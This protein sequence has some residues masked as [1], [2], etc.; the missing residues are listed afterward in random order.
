MLVEKI[1]ER[2]RRRDALCALVRAGQRRAGDERVEDQKCG[3]HNGQNAANALRDLL[4][5]ARHGGVNA[6][7]PDQAKQTPDDAEH[8]IRAPV[9]IERR[10]AVIPRYRS[11][12]HLLPPAAQIFKRRA[13]DAARDENDRAVLL[14]ELIETKR[15]DR[16]AAAVDRLKRPVNQADAQLDLMGDEE[17]PALLEHKTGN[18]SD[19]KDPEQ[20]RQVH[21]ESKRAILRV[22]KGRF[23]FVEIARLAL[24]LPALSLL[25]RD[26]VSGKLLLVFLTGHVRR[27][28]QEAALKKVRFVQKRSVAFLRI[29]LRFAQL[30]V[31]IQ[32]VDA[33]RRA[34]RA[35]GDRAA[36][37]VARF[38]H[39]FCKLGKAPELMMQLLHG[40]RCDHDV[41]KQNGEKRGEDDPS[42]CAIYIIQQRGKYRNHK[43][44]DERE[45]HAAQ[46][47]ERH[48]DIALIVPL[49]RRVV[50]QADL[51]SLM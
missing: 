4:N 44:L 19:E 36:D 18:A 50:A 49:E 3:E 26:A 16:C 48:A 38:A 27:G 7:E 6:L 13:D 40:D 15:D 25:R 2:G 5:P 10:A 30:V 23:V 9:D 33:L 14:V 1:L 47:R 43:Q 22:F 24:R 31:E 29:F 20:L 35:L 8:Q 21:A 46:Q 39:A 17:C 51:F 37:R 11:E 12:D 41:E 45:A 32:L 42:D 28:A 34:D